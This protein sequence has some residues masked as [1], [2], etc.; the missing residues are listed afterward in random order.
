MHVLQSNISSQKQIEKALRKANVT[1]HQ[2]ARKTS[3]QVRDTAAL[4]Q[5]ETRHVNKIIL[6]LKTVKYFQLGFSKS[7]LSRVAESRTF[8]YIYIYILVF[9]YCSFITQSTQDT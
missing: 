2:Y 5:I 6:H 1:P 8:I 3:G 7:C 9:I 4:L